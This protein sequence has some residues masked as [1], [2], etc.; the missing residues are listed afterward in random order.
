MRLNTDVLPFK[1]KMLAAVLLSLNQQNKKY[2]DIQYSD[3][4]CK[5]V[6]SN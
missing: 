6:I 5:N 3:I 4:Q 2:F 1:L